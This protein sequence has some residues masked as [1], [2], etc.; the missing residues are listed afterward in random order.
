MSFF[1]KLSVL[2]VILA[3]TGCGKH[4]IS[5]VVNNAHEGKVFINNKP[6]KEIIYTASGTSEKDSLYFLDLEKGINQFRFVL[7]DNTVIDTLLDY[8]GGEVYL[9]VDLKTGELSGF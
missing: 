3:L 1:V 9:A 2:V 4:N 7:S 5:M 8:R 6:L